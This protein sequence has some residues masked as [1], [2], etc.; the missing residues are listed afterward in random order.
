MFQSRCGLP[1]VSGPAL[2]LRGQPLR[3][4][5]GTSSRPQGPCP[6]SGIWRGG[7]DGEGLGGCVGCARDGRWRGRGS[8]IN[9][10]APG[11][12]A[13]PPGPRGRIS[14]R[15]ACCAATQNT[16][17]GVRAPRRA[18]LPRSAPAQGQSP[19]L[20]PRRLWVLRT[21]PGPRG[22]PH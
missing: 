20:N 7:G 15:R 5:P 14:A 8:A 1:G 21:F 17:R 9:T 16:S 12:A 13:A 18:P 22:T 4:S 3:W 10:P 6:A 19:F 2:G 11:R